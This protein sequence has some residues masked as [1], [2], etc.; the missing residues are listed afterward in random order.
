MKTESMR[1]ANLR[2]EQIYLWELVE[3]RKLCL[4]K[5]LLMPRR[6]IYRYLIKTMSCQGRL[7]KS[8]IVPQIGKFRV[9][10]TWFMRD[11]E[12]LSDRKRRFQYAIIESAPNE[13]PY[14]MIEDCKLRDILPYVLI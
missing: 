7:Q 8:I 4:I 14:D 10:F 11:N 5:R 1:S 12:E 13:H 3:C 9:L 2:N 6:Y